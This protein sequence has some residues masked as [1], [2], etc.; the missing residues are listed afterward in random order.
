MTINPLLG[1]PFQDVNDLFHAWMSV[2]PMSLTRRHRHPD[3][4]Q[5]LRLSE[6]DPADPIV[7][8]PRQFMDNWLENRTV[9][10]DFFSASMPDRV[11]GRL[12]G[13][14]TALLEVT[15][16]SPFLIPSFRSLAVWAAAGFHFGLYISLFGNTFAFFLHDTIVLLIAFI[17][18]VGSQAFMSLPSVLY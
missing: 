16:G 6:P 14:R 9:W 11:F 17:P 10:Y 7:W 1:L 13:I 12:L 18:W 4:H 3:Q 8:T 2:K 15:S 5:I